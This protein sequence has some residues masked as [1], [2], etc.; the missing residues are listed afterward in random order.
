LQKT[1]Y[2]QYQNTDFILMG[3][4]MTHSDMVKQRV[5]SAI[6]QYMAENNVA[7]EALAARLGV[8]QTAIS[9]YRQGRMMPKADTLLR[10]A[11]VF[12]LD[13]N[14]MVYVE[15]GVEPESVLA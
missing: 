6:K 3:D 5:A 13:L 2:P 12:G 9:A 10:M 1:C 11:Q 7:Q 8:H 4:S 15:T 14:E